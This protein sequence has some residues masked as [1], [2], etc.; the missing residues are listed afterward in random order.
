MKPRE[1]RDLTK[2]EV[3]TRKEELEREIFNLRIRQATKQIENP[4]KI[5]TIRRELARITTIL[6][7]DEMNI[8]KLASKGESA[9]G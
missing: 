7:E 2:E 3:L 5:R 9:H 1:I 6:R 8:R 4:L